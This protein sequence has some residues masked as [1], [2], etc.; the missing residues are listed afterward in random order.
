VD[1]TKRIWDVFE[2]QCRCINTR[3]LHYVALYKGS[4]MFT[5]RLTRDLQR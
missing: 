5:V 1:N 3:R 2:T 4:F